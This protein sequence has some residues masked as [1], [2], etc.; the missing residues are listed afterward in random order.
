VFVVVHF[1]SLH[2]ELLEI[3]CLFVRLFVCLVDG[4][5]VGWS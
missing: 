1:Q 4:S 5:V 2:E 3:E